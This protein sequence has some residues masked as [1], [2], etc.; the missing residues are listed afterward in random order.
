M[1]ETLG[2]VEIGIGNQSLWQ[3]LNA[4]KQKIVL[5]ILI[6]YVDMKLSISFIS[7]YMLTA[8]S[9]FACQRV[10]KQSFNRILSQIQTLVSKNN[11]YNIIITL[12]LYFDIN[13]NIQGNPQRMRLEKGLY[14][15][16][17]YVCLLIFMIPVNMFLSQS[18]H[19]ICH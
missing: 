1:T 8:Q 18:N 5:I 6:N 11:K 10:K 2:C 13:V 17:V 12:L 7:V 14:G 15:V 19:E 3:S 9:Y 4:F 16:Y